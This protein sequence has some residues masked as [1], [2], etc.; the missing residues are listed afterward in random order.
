[1]KRY[2]IAVAALLSSACMVG[3]KYKKPN[4]PV[5][6]TFKEPPPAGWKSAQPSD[7]M[8]RGKWWELYKDP[9]LNA[10]EELVAINNQNVLAAEANYRV[11]AAAARVARAALFPTLST[12]PSI[13]VSGRGPGRT[14]NLTGTGGNSATVSVTG[15]NTIYN[16]PFDVSWQLDVWGAIRRSVTSNIDLA[17]AAAAQV[18]NVRLLYQSEL[19]IDYFQLHGTDTERDLLASTVKYYSEFLELTRRRFEGGI[20]SEADVAQAEEQLYSAQSQLTDL[21]VARAQFEHAIAVLTGRSP[22]EVTVRPARLRAPPPPV[23]VALPSTLL[24]RRPDIAAAER[25]A[26]A[27]NEQIGIAMAAYYPQVNLSAS[28]GF[29]SSSFLN[30][31]SWPSRFW[32]VGPQLAQTLFDA[33]R[34]H[35]QVQMAEGQYDATAATYRQT[36][37]TA[38]QQVEDNLAALRILETETAQ[39]ERAI[40]AAQRALEI[41]TAQY[42]GGTVPYLQ[43]LTSQVALLSNQRAMITVLE[44]RL[45]A[46]VSLVQAL[47]GG[48]DTSKL[49]SPSD[50]RSMK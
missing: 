49:P 19:A 44:R 14:A 36:V 23:P 31:I 30:W 9:D 7:E 45:V 39:L 42:T 34:R 40:G 20:A 37:L 4:M 6:V 38:F 17:Q 32:T 28:A 21:G 35:G 15:V 16:L 50:I 5:P 3:P 22:A 46:S 1:M 47:G 33:G 2:A 27:A 41:S 29:S 13:T 8:I 26:A 24:E 25:N 10:L 12:S 18:E 48:W 11:A 43:V